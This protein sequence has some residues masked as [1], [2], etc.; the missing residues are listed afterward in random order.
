M[1]RKKSAPPLLDEAQA[2]FLAG[3]LSIAMASRDAGGFPS[4]TRGYGCRVSPDRREVAVYVSRRRSADLIR[5]LAA[6]APLAV[7][8]SRPMTHQTLQLKGEGAQLRALEAE[9]RDLVSASRAAF[10]AEIIALGYPEH[11]SRAIMSGEPEDTF[12]VVFEPNAV[13]D[14]TPGPQAGARLDP[15]P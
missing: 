3:P 14:Q 7:V 4:V 2:E 9:E 1:P 11:F 8:F 13:F 5:D 12:A 10:S 15:K 6:G